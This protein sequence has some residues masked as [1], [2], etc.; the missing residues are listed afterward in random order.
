MHGD[1]RLDNLFFGEDGRFTTIDWQGVGCARP[2]FDVAY[3]LTGN[4]EIDAALSAE[5][6]LVRSYHDELAANG[7]KSYP[8]EECWRD[9]QLTKLFLIYRLMLGGEMIDL[10]NERGQVL[11]DRVVVRL[12]ALLPKEH[13]DRLL[14]PLLTKSIGR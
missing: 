13:P 6:R 7:V 14:P 4:M 8:F 10:S 3:F 5:E 2:A 9:Y 1:Y 12:C 11:L